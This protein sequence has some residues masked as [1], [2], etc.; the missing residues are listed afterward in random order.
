MC[1]DRRDGGVRRGREREDSR[2]EVKEGGRGKRSSRSGGGRRVG[3]WDS[4][5]GRKG[6][7][8]GRV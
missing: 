2:R 4:Q 8:E 7:A 5:D 1:R 6:G 3:G